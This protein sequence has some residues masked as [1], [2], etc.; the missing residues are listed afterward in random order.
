MEFTGYISDY[1]V[2]VSAPQPGEEVA[3]NRLTIYVKVEYTDHKNEDNN[4]NKT[5]NFFSEFPADQNLL[6]VQD[7]LH[8]TIIEQ[9]V[10]DIFSDAF[11]NW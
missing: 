4:W 3:F 10:S 9:L 11:T 5:F 8:A 2:T 1:R 6:D 7:D